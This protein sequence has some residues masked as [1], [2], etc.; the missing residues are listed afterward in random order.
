[1]GKTRAPH[2]VITVHAELPAVIDNHATSNPMVDNEFEASSLAIGGLP[3]PSC[4]NFHTD[5][6][7]RSQAGVVEPH[8]HGQGT[9]PSPLCSFWSRTSLQVYYEPP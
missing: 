1:M 7:Y 3:G 2:D 9:A 6:I 5:E 4:S 8:V